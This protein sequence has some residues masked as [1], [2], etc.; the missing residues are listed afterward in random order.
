MTM[1]LWVAVVLI[2]GAGAPARPID[3]LTSESGL[4]T[5]EHIPAVARSG[6]GRE[7]KTFVI[8]GS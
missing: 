5:A 8:N 6:A 3:E 4:V 7:A 2:G 1:L